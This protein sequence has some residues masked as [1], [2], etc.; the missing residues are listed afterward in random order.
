M[1]TSC[2]ILGI[3]NRCVECN[4]T[5]YGVSVAC[6]GF[7]Q[8]YSS[9]RIAPPSKNSLI[10]LEL[11]EMKAAS[12]LDSAIGEVVRAVADGKIFRMRALP[13][14]VSWKPSGAPLKL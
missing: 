2:A 13:W 11:L 3:A 10:Q 4:C 7:I 14:P 12:D 9:D 6:A 1:N 5:G 8:D